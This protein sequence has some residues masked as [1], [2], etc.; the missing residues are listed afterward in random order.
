HIIDAVIDPPPSLADAIS[1]HNLTLLTTAATQAGLLSTLTSAK[2]ITIFAPNDAAFTSALTALGGVTNVSPATLANVLKNHVI[3]GT[4]VYAAQ[5][6]GANFTS[7]GGES[8]SFSTNSSGSFVKSGNST[9]KVLA[10]DILASNGVVHLIDT[11]LLNNDSDASAASS[12]FQSATSAAAS[13]ATASQTAPIGPTASGSGG[14]GSGSGSGSN[15]G[16]NGS[17]GGKSAALAVDVPFRALALS[18]V[19]AAFGVAIVL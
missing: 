18:L 15:N 9:A 7:A 4:T 1:S 14:S 5:L 16:T 12:A 3:N 8:F 10:T 11:V 19:L 6:G 17:N 13:A 2:G